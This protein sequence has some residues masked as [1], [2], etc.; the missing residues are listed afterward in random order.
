M[1]ERFTVL[2]LSGRHRG[3][4]RIGAP[5]DGQPITSLPP[6]SA[7]LHVR[8]GVRGQCRECDRGDP[9][10]MPRVSSVRPVRSALDLIAF[11]LGTGR[12]HY[13]LPQHG[14]VTTLRGRGR[15]VGARGSGLG[16]GNQKQPG[17]QT[18]RCCPRYR[19]LRRV[20]V[21]SLRPA[22]RGELWRPPR[23]S[24]GP[25]ASRKRASGETRPCSR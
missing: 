13:W 2:V 14:R 23:F 24:S 22:V 25:A 15:E 17:A 19:W 16:A 10:P 9:R 8:L 6:A 1:S 4:C 18:C 7:R 11:L 20:P 21:P 5:Q 12:R 3:S